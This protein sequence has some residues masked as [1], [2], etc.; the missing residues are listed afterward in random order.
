M[1]ECHWTVMA[2]LTATDMHYWGVKNQSAIGHKLLNTRSILYLFYHGMRWCVET[3]S[4][5]CPIATRGCHIH[6]VTMEENNTGTIKTA[7]S[8]YNLGV[9]SKQ[10]S[11]F[12]TKAAII[13]IRC[14]WDRLNFINGNTY[15]ILADFDT[16]QCML[17]LLLLLYWIVSKGITFGNH[18]DVIKWKHF[19]RYSP[20]SSEFPS[21]KPV[22][23]SFHVLFD[24][25]LE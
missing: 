6:C 22:T 1:D 5:L 3:T 7:F 16:I 14:L 19:P 8:V 23:R 12:G 20:V 11:L 13:K 21:Q 24:L 25:R 10:K 9:V 18:D 17:Y 15:T 2:Q 4:P